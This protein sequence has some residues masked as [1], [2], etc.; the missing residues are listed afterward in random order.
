MSK[1]RA[2]ALELFPNIRSTIQSSATPGELWI[3]LSARLQAHYGEEP[4][5]AA[6]S[7]SDFAGN[8]YLYA[9][10]CHRAADWHAQEAA[11]IE[12]FESIVP[13]AIRSG[14]SVYDRIVRD[15]VNYL[16]VPTIKNSAASFGYS[17]SSQQL[18]HFIKEVDNSARRK[19]RRSVKR[20]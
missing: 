3:E 15:L 20:L 10:R 11:G 16:G 14:K 1:W 6:E 2:K 9:L 5:S 8:V 7:S 18:E 17:L 12:F 13:F 4:I 19:A